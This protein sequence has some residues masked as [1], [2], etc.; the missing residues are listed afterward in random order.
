MKDPTLDI[1]IERDGIKEVRKTDQ[2]NQGRPTVYLDDNAEFII[3]MFNPNEKKIGVK[4]SLNGIV[5][6]NILILR[7][8]ERIW[9]DRFV[10][11]NKKFK[12]STYAVDRSTEAMDA[13]RRNGEISAEFYSEEEIQLIPKYVYRY[14]PEYVPVHVP[15]IQPNPWI[16]PSPWVYPYSPYRHTNV[17][18]SSSIG[19][20]SIPSGVNTIASGYCSYAAGTLASDASTTGAI[21]FDKKI[22]TGMIEKGEQSSQTFKDMQVELKKHSF[23]SKTLYIMPTSS[24]PMYSDTNRTY[25]TGCRRRQRRGEVYCSKCGTKF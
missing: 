18:Y 1:A 4:L 17:M 23:C 21:Q 22:E 16:Y 6:G 10:D 9:L 3:S 7:P 15:L 12:F 24:M 14:Y 25:C 8:G 20:D 13:I 11:D 2:S 5:Q 19:S